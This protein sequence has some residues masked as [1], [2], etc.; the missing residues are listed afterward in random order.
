[1]YGNLYFGG[2]FTPTP[3]NGWVQD[4]AKTFVGVTPRFS[5]RDKISAN[6]NVYF[7]YSQG[8]KSGLFNASAVP[9][10]PSTKAPELVEPEKLDSYEVGNQVGAGQ[11]VQL[12][13]GNVPVQI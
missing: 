6:T 8:F 7:T 1:V 5:L 10:T 12:Q 9:V 2:F 13:R 11:L 3:P 4:G